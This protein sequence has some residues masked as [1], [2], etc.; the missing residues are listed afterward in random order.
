MEHVLN[1]IFLIILS[2]VF[3]ALSVWT[4][5][6]NY[7]N[8]DLTDEHPIL[9]DNSLI[10]N[11]VLVL[12][13]LMF[14]CFIYEN[15]HLAK[16]I[17]E[18]N[19]SKL[20]MAISFIASI[21]ALIWVL[22]C[23][24]GPVADQR[25]I[26]IAASEFNQGDYSLLGKGEYM[27][28]YPQN[29]GLVSLMRVLFILFGDGNYVAFQIC[30]AISVFFIVYGIYLFS[31]LVSSNRVIQLMS[32]IMAFLC[33]PMY[34]YAP[35][36]YGELL[37]TAF[38]FWG[39]IYFEKISQHF[40]IIN[41]VGLLLTFFFAITFRK[42]TLIFVVAIFC[43]CI[44]KIVLRQNWGRYLC[45][46]ILLLLA[47]KLNSVGTNLLYGAHMEENSKGMPA[48]LWI[49]MGLNSTESKF[50]YGWDDRSA[51]TIFEN[52]D[53]DPEASKEEAI[54]II[55]SF[56]EDNGASPDKLIAFYGTKIATQWMN[57]M[58]QGFVMNN[59]I[60]REQ[61]WF[62]NTLYSSE[63]IWKIFNKYMNIYQIIVYLGTV[64]S[65]I[66][67]IRTKIGMEKLVGMIVV[68]G[69]F[70]FS[71]IWEAKTR[72]VFPYV[73][74]LIPYSMVGMEKLLK[75]LF[76][77]IKMVKNNESINTK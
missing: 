18:I 40:N 49:Q 36:V 4:Y 5:A 13:A 77:K 21:L 19:L 33:I 57:P 43:V 11:G 47:M 73:L 17:N 39:L 7:I 46:I 20:A 72:Y 45:V 23:G 6:H 62:A 37:S 65:G 58:Y 63:V 14:F 54:G 41:I 42:N 44:T 38:A 60:E 29:L 26:C 27:S 66:Y 71:I 61:K 2:V 30:S 32:M 25:M 74:V 15:N 8:T 12:I 75:Y 53:Y 35:F 28:I 31:S 9:V 56:W 67:F 52:N 1:R 16:I 22:I 70:I 3:F 68:F 24:A 51:L 34:L 59:N 50:G 69:G 55:N 76:N 10:L 48:I 64:F